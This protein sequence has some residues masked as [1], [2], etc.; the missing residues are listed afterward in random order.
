MG[1]VKV[2]LTDGDIRLRLSENE[3]ATVLDGRQILT[4]VTDNLVI[5]LVPVDA[6]DSSM[7][8][9]GSVHAVMIPAAEARTPSMVDPLIYESPPGHQPYILV[10]MDRQRQGSAVDPLGSAVHVERLAAEKP[11]DGD[12]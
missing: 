7:G 9:V 6:S 3:V 11:D 4:S 5:A 2:R 12:T 10:E 1:T 8:T